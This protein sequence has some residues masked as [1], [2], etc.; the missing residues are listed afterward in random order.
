MSSGLTVGSNLVFLN[1][2]EDGQAYTEG[3]YREWVKEEGFIDFE[4]QVLPDGVSF[5]R[6]GTGIG[7]E[8]GE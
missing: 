7:I 1:T 5:V 6:A 2:T 8:T 4:S 3:E